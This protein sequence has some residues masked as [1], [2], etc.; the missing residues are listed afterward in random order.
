MAKSKRLYKKGDD[1]YSHR[2]L[3]Y[4]QTN[5]EDPI[6]RLQTIRD[7]IYKIETKNEKYVGKG[8]SNAASLKKQKWLTE[9]LHQSGFRKTYRFLKAKPDE[10]LQLDGKSYGILKWVEHHKE[11]FQYNSIQNCIEGI[12]LVHE[13]HSKNKTFLEEGSHYFPRSKPYDK[14]VDRYQRFHANIPIIR[15]TVSPSIL[16]EIKKWGRESLKNISR[17]QPYS[18]GTKVILHGDVAHHNFIRTAEGELYLIDFDLASIGH[19]IHDYLQ[20]A[21]RILPYLQWDLKKL[22]EIPILSEQLK[23]PYFLYSLMY[24]TDIYREWNRVIQNNLLQ[25]NRWLNILF[26][27]TIEQF[28]KRQIFY[29]TLKVMVK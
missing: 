4:F 21:N 12:L 2:L 6:V 14:W 20:Y 11:N 22:S 24:P 8:F 28:E 10:G 3:S 23:D 19:P 13:F 15:S 18:P 27:M 5:I 9:K 17:L 29:D 1:H 25:S 26:D 7:H 16:K